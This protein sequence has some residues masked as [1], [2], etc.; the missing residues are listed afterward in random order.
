[1]ITEPRPVP[2]RPGMPWS[3]SEW[4]GCYVNE[5][6]TRLHFAERT[7]DYF[8]RVQR[9]PSGSVFNLLAARNAAGHHNG[10]RRKS[11]YRWSQTPLR[12]LDG[13]IVVL[14]RK[15]TRL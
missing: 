15:S 1:M 4:S 13:N 7:C 11:A 10:I 8:C 9:T 12:D 6:M 5:L 14:D 3:A 2:P